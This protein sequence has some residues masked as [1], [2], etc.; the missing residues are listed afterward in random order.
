MTTIYLTTITVQGLTIKQ[1]LAL[2]LFY[3]FFRSHKELILSDEAVD[4][5]QKV[6][7]NKNKKAILN[8]DSFRKEYQELKANEFNATSS[9]NLT[10]SYFSVHPHTTAFGLLFG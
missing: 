7:N 10:R 8:I 3:D 4:A 9:D 6:R 1:A 2:G 5:V